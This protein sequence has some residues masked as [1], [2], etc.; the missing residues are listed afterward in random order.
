MVDFK[1]PLR[2]VSFNL[3][4]L[5]FSQEPY[6]IEENQEGNSVKEEQ[7]RRTADRRTR[8]V[9]R[10]HNAVTGGQKTSLRVPIQV[11]RIRYTATRSYG[12]SRTEPQ[13]RY[14]ATA[15]TDLRA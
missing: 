13:D 11:Q 10:S 4:L 1:R 12:S 2:T 9:G 8:M 7:A 5:M 6:N 3:L 15:T 14:T